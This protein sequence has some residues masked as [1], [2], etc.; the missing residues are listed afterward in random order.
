MQKVMNYLLDLVE[1]EDF[2]MQIKNLR[3]EV[4]IPE[5]GL[6]YIQEDKDTFR[7]R[8]LFYMPKGVTQAQAKQANLGLREITKDFPVRELDITVGFRMYFFHN[9]LFMDNFENGI[10][11]SNLCKIVDLRGDFQEYAPIYEERMENYKGGL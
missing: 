9:E 5:N 1:S 3:K 11:F 10:F 8:S 7:G 6:P 2:Q 4:G